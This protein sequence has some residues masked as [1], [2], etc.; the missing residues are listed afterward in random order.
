MRFYG[1][2]MSNLEIT[3]NWLKMQATFTGKVYFR[4][5]LFE[6]QKIKEEVAACRKEVFEKYP[7]DGK[8]SFKELLEEAKKE[9]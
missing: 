1:L 5:Q 8:S 9:N 6:L 3:E 4:Q 7:Y 2:E